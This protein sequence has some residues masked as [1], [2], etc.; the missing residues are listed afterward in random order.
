MT[1]FKQQADPDIIVEGGA[2]QLRATVLSQKFECNVRYRVE[3]LFVQSLIDE[4][5]LSGKYP[6][7]STVYDKIKVA[8]DL[9]LVEY[10]HGHQRD[11][12]S[13]KIAWLVFHNQG[14]RRQRRLIQEGFE[15]L[16]NELIAKAYAEG[17]GIEIMTESVI[18]I[19]GIENPPKIY[20]PRQI[21]GNLYLMP[22]RSRNKHVPPTGQAARLVEFRKGR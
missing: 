16:T 19:A 13:N 20:R 3:S 10:D 7:N 4:I 5:E 2:D 11:P 18:Q 1:Q 21:G 22:P 15:A 14:Y 12:L 9:D 6:Y 17:K 8:L